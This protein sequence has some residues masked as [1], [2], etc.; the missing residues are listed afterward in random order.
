MAKSSQK[1]K[2][3]NI[4]YLIF[5][6][7]MLAFAV[8]SAFSSFKSSYDKAVIQEVTRTYDK[9]RSDSNKI[10][11]NVKSRGLPTSANKKVRAN[12]TRTFFI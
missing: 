3:H 8:L 4:L 5:G 1:G 6:I 7:I 10:C 9:K 2:Q 11:Q 12:M